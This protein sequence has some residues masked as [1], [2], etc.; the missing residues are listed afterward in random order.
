[1]FISFIK[2]KKKSMQ[3]KLIVW[4]FKHS[5]VII[6]VYFIVALNV[7]R[8]ITRILTMQGFLFDTD[9]YNFSMDDLERS[10]YDYGVS[11]LADFVT[12]IAI[13]RLIYVKN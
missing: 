3:E 4:K 7:A 9:R 2:N 13:L 10:M 11:S 8:T 12:S 5:L 6:G 1:M